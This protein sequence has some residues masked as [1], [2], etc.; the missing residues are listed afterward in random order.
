MTVKLPYHP[1]R[2]AKELC[3]RFLMRCLEL[4]WNA[5]EIETLRALWWKYHDRQGKLIQRKRDAP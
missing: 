1:T 5:D 3:V 4:G 2:T